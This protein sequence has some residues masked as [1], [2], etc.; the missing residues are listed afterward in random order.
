MT[1]NSTKKNAITHCKYC[2]TEIRDAAKVCYRCGRD[3]R[4][5][6]SNFSNI[7]VLA[8]IGLLVLSFMQLNEAR[9]ERI[10]A[11]RASQDANTSLRAADKALTRAREAEQ[12]AITTA[13]HMKKLAVALTDS[14]VTSLTV[15]GPFQ[16]VHL[17]YKIEQIDRISSILREIGVPQKSIDEAI[18]TLVSRVRGDHMKRV[19]NLINMKLSNDKKLFKDISDIDISLWNINRAR[20]IMKENAI[21]SIGELRETIL[22]MEFYEKNKKLR[23]ENKWQ[24]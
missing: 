19:L 14:V 11:G 2:Q 12:K 18:S 16:Y 24:G 22:D 10:S 13:D 3:Q 6:I 17:K 21:E 15:P 9:K 23:R 8:S 20:K 7:S 1:E 4:W 5:F